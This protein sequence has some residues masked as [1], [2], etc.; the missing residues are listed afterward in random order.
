[1]KAR[2][3]LLL[4]VPAALVAAGGIVWLQG[5]RYEETENAY[6]KAHIIAVTADVSGRV[7]EVGVRDNQPVQAGALLFRI[8]PVPF[9]LELERAEAQMAVVRTELEGLRAEH[10][11][12]LAES[13]EAAE[14]IRFLT[15][16]L[17]RQEKLK[18]RGMGLEASYDEARHNL[19][20]AR[21]RLEGATE[22]AHRVQ[23]S[24]GGDLRRP[25]HEHPRYRQALAARDAAREDFSRTTVF[26]P[27][28]G[29]V[30]N[31]KLQPGERVERGVPVFTLIDDGPV[32]V[33]A[34]FKETQLTHIRE[35]QRA[36]VVA[37][38]FPNTRWSG[39]ITTIAPATR[40]EFALL[41]AQNASGN[42]VKVVQRVPVMVALEAA[43]SD[44]PPLRAGMTVTVQVDT[45]HQ[46]SL[47]ALWAR[48]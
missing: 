28:T 36:T 7:I 39:K 2:A 26:A 29:V 33:E 27:S 5:G 35:G 3:L 25:A 10:R 34:N 42:W 21:R 30:S 47:L 43:A 16:Q 8:D 44:A 31:M 17:E 12:A 6:V 48:R 38:A 23:A 9:R 41:P 11:V 46:R 40:A 1:M 45:G 19:E 18:E 15:R 37:D 4:A 14:R 20:A 22:R 24:L 13:A 32:W